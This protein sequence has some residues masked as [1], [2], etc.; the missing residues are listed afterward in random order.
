MPAITLPV[1]RGMSLSNCENSSLNFSFASFTNRCCHKKNLISE[2]LL[3]LNLV[4]ALCPF[5]TSIRRASRTHGGKKIAQV[6]V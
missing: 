1:L 6:I 3:D 5:R 4:V 2:R